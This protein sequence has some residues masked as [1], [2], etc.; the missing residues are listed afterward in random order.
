MIEAWN[1]EWQFISLILIGC[2]KWNFKLK[3][4]FHPLLNGEAKLDDM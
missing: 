3:F 2:K 4:E 1:I